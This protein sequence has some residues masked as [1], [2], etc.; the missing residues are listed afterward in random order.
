MLIKF[1][2]SQTDLIAHKKNEMRVEMNTTL[3]L[4]KYESFN[5]R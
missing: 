5:D 1:Y 4:N 3:K 2:H